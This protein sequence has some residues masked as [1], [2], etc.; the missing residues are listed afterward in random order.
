MI[1][2][3]VDSVGIGRD[4]AGGGTIH[5]VA[6]LKGLL[7]ATRDAEFIASGKAYPAGVCFTTGIVPRVEPRAHQPGA[8]GV[9]VAGTEVSTLAAFRFV[10]DA[11]GSVAA[12]AVIHHEAFPLDVCGVS[13]LGGGCA[14]LTAATISACGIADDV[15]VVAGICGTAGE[16]VR[17]VGT[18]LVEVELGALGDLR[19]RRI[20]NFVMQMA[21]TRI[22]AI[23][24]R[25]QCLTLLHP[26]AADHIHIPQMI[27]VRGITIDVV[28]QLHV[29][30]RAI[31]TPFAVR[32]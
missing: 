28:V 26:L 8:V 20:T 25:S 12:A 5:Q 32:V 27:V 11:A 9:V 10:V 7:R 18:V 2:W 15:V 13:N 23:T 3:Q 29:I 1:L 31:R 17:G 16:R 21:R 22:S 24:Q 19:S 4:L 14:D 6:V 30:T